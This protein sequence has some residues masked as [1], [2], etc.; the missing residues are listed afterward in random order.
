LAAGADER[1]YQGWT[2][3]DKLAISGGSAGGHLIGATLNI[4]PDLSKAAL[5]YV[6]FV[7]VINTMYDES[8]PST[9]EEFLECGNPKKESEIGYMLT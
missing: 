4:R 9:V 5:L 1:V 2:T 6:S 7:A 3:R 8:L